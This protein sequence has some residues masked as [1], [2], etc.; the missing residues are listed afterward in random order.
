MIYDHN[1]RVF[2]IKHNNMQYIGIRC[3]YYKKLNFI[4]TLIDCSNPGFCSKIKQYNNNKS[5][6][7][8]CGCRREC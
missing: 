4:R 5:L 1:F 6:N 8:D 3:I 7:K 2:Q